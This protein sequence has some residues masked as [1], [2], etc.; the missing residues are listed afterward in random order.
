MPTISPRRDVQVDALDDLRGRRGPGGGRASRAPRTPSRRSRGVALRVA[1]GHLAADHARM[2]RSSLTAPARQSSVSTVRAVAQHG[3]RVG[4]LRDLVE[5]VRD[6]DAGDALRLEL[7]QQV[8]QRVAVVLVQ[9]RGRLVEDQQLAP[10][11]D[12]ALAISTSCCLPTPRSVISVA[13]DSFE[14]DLAQQLARARVRR[15][16]VDDAAARAARCRGRCSR[17]STA[18]APAP[19]P[20]G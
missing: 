2:I 6:Q 15:V 19:A 10:R 11:L 7:E 9:A 20:G 14:A 16:P 8:E 1:V 12:S 3:D 13:G 18:A 17:R 5:L 4:D